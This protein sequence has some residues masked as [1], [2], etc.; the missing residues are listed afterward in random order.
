[1]RPEMD[2]LLSEVMNAPLPS[3]YRAL[4]SADANAMTA[5]DCV[6]YLLA[7][8]NAEEAFWQTSPAAQ[9]VAA[10]LQTCVDRL[11][12]VDRRAPFDDAYE[13]GEDALEFLAE[14]SAADRYR[15]AVSNL[16][17]AGDRVPDGE[18]I[19]LQLLS[20]LLP[21]LDETNHVEHDATLITVSSVY[22]SAA[23][24]QWTATIALAEPTL[25]RIA[26]THVDSWAKLEALEALLHCRP[27][28]AAPLLLEAITDGVLKGPE[29]DALHALDL[30]GRH[31]QPEFGSVLT[32][33]RDLSATT[34][35]PG[36]RAALDT[37]IAHAAE[38]WGWAEQ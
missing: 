38:L 14:Q 20:S 19:A 36:V 2:R 27:N 23:D 37:A 3:T 34:I 24:H 8:A 35:T 15:W 32:Q 6:L 17:F 5:A 10:T 1:M 26:T 11:A 30:A 16:V 31:P 18:Q 22:A 7:C 25:R 28:F 9:D 33:L 13:P 4:A 29:S 21:V 12:A